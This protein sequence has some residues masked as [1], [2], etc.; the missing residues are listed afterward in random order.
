MYI[1]QKVIKK[2]FLK[3]FKHEKKVHDLSENIYKFKYTDSFSFQWKRFNITQQDSYTKQQL[4]YRRL[5]DNTK[6]KLSNFKKKKLLEVGSGAGRFT[7][8]FLKSGCYLFTIDSSKSIFTN[9]ANYK[10]KINKRFHFYIRTSTEQNIF[11]NNSFDYV[12]CYGVIQ[13]TKNPL[14]TIDF[15]INKTKPGGLLSIDLYRKF[16][17][18]MC[19]TTPKYIWRPI[20]TKMNKKKLLQI[21]KKYIPY[22]LPFDT[23]IKKTFGKFGLILAGLIPIPC[24]NY[25]YLNL[26][27]EEKTQWAILDTFDALSAKYDYP[28]T[29]NEINCFLKK[30][31]NIKYKIFYGSNGIVVNLKKF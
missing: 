20:T 27:K 29:I 28:F 15:L 12:F 6:W 10:K 14:A 17:F 3:K 11:K 7:E 1:L 2:E 16:Y 19:Y 5:V 18:P 13:H 8:I 21:I 30:Y 23:F 4:T 25:Y 31:K 9:F 24:W 22:Y 26:S